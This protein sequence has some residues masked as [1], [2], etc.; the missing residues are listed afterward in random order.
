VAPWKSRLAG[1]STTTSLKTGEFVSFCPGDDYDANRPKYSAAA[2]HQNGAVT[3][4][5][6][7]NTPQCDVNV[8]GYSASAQH[9]EMGA[10]G[11]AV[12]VVTLLT[13]PRE[14]RCSGRHI[15]K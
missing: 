7:E 3:S 11:A 4:T 12:G 13:V 2:R 5:C 9:Q 1:R 14:H 6:R 8:P 15:E 10:E